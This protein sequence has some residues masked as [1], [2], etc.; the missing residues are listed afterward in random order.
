[1]DWIT[2]ADFVQQN[3]LA[4]LGGL[5]IMQI[6]ALLLLA[7][8]WQRDRRQYLRLQ[9]LLDQ[10]DT[11]KSIAANLGRQ[12][13]RLVALESALQS[14]VNAQAQ[15]QEDQAFAVQQVGYYRYNAFPDTGGELSFS[16][17]LLDGRQ[18]G[19]VLTSLYGRQEARVYAKQV[20]AGSSS[21]R[22]SPEEQE[23][24]RRALLS[25]KL[26]N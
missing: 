19:F 15:L 23:A 13:Q 12:E 2:V 3:Q 20:K 8:L 16:L 24:I 14:L 21:A 1:M 17:V 9:P 11:T 4:L 5:A 6:I 10:A 26:G 7:I 22:L 25:K 18:D